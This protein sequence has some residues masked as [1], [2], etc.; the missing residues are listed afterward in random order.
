M[1][2]RKTSSFILAVLIL[3]PC[4]RKRF[5]FPQQDKTRIVICITEA[6]GDVST[7]DQPVSQIGQLTFD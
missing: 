2:Q 6:N 1:T 5:S 3:K 7:N 4:S